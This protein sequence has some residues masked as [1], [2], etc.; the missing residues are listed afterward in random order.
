M[1]W[2]EAKYCRFARCRRQCPSKNNYLVVIICIIIYFV[3]I[4]YCH[5]EHSVFSYK[6]FAVLDLHILI[7]LLDLF[8]WCETWRYLYYVSCKPV[9]SFHVLI[10]LFDLTNVLH[11]TCRFCT[12]K[13]YFPLILVCFVYKHS[14]WL[15]LFY[16]RVTANIG[17]LYAGR[18]E[19]KTQT[20]RIY[21]KELYI[22]V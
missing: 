4:W 2:Q 3:L 6:E 14:L 16:I 15:K 21:L 20:L 5:L 18:N 8:L 13:I 10:V 9:K 12:Q 7:K 17:G 1:N 22:L 19:V 11:D